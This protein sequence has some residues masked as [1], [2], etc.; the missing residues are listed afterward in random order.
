MKIY[1]YLPPLVLACLTLAF[2][3]MILTPVE[4][5]RFW[6]WEDFLY[7]NFPYRSFAAASLARGEF[8]FWNP[9]MFG[10][11][12]FFAD[13]QSAV[14]YPLNLAL[15][16]F[17]NAGSLSAYTLEWQ[18]VLHYFLAAYFTFRFLRLTG[19]EPAA[20]ILGGV[21][22][23]FSGF[24]VTHAMHINFIHVFVWLP[25]I[26]ELFERALASGKLRYAML[27]AVV[28]GL[29]TMGGYPQ[30][31]LYINY[32]A[33]LYWL[34]HELACYTRRGEGWSLSA[35]WR[36]MGLV[37]LVSLINLG[38]NAVQFLPAAEMAEHTGRS[39]MTYAASIEHSLYP[40]QLVKLLC[41]GFFGTQY[42]SANTYWAGGYSAF[43]ETCLFVGVLPLILALW[44]LSAVRKNRHVA[45][46]AVLA[47]I[48]LW[49]AL[50]GYGLLYKLFF[51][52][53]PGFG[54]FRIPGRFSAFA[55]FALAVLAAHGWSMIEGARGAEGGKSRGAG[56]GYL[57]RKSTKCLLIITGIAFGA[58]LLLLTVTKAGLIEG[59]FQASGRMPRA[60]VNE[61]AQ[62][63]CI[64]SLAWIA[65]AGILLV[66]AS[67]WL[68]GKLIKVPW[69][70]AML[71]VLF[72][73][74]ELYSFGA[75]FLKGTVSP[76]EFYPETSMVSRLREEGKR[77]LFRINARHLEHTGIMVLRRNQGSLDRLFLIEGYNPLQ[78][79][80]RLGH[81]ETERRFDLLNVKYR[82]ELDLE[83][84]SAGLAQRKGYL[85]RAFMV[86]RWQ[87]VESDEGIL[88]LLN[89]P[90]FD[91]RNEA[92]LEQALN[93]YM[94]KRPGKD[95]C[96]ILK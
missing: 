15:N 48:S 34:V 41:P 11:M 88:A 71:A 54:R 14:L 74:L 1:P 23:A 59:L 83:R 36:R 16:L 73:F 27:C 24:L 62:G 58:A 45:F 28:F 66:S 56:P 63:A 69:V 76:D 94:P 9:F 85:P 51:N 5:S 43:W 65:G 3:W 82:I 49:L 13:I 68:P 17:A 96:L 47:F 46:T 2:F 81:V 38:L 95:I 92:V 55:S 84:K 86:H 22:F 93:I 19:L 90:E 37:A 33:A 10:G 77:E 42:P 57:S 6:L 18:V 67:T 31:S 79:K 20:S 26:L 12:P 91:H 87:V 4:S 8:P 40:M 50:G 60:M 64:R 70:T 29:S 80:R 75:P 35:A 32:V 52:F 25:L 61:I 21:T 78:L 72:V 89:S 44:S 53:A 30:Y 39:T 7:Q